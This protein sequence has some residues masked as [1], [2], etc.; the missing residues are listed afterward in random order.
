MN[1]SEFTSGGGCLIGDK[2]RQVGEIQEGK[3]PL[4]LLPTL[5]ANFSFIP[6]LGL[7]MGDG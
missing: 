2:F 3:S 4:E 6:Q 5:S 1:I 7:K